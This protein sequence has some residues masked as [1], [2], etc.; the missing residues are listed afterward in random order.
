MSR[1]ALLA[2]LAFGFLAGLIVFAPLE[3][4]LR[5]S[6][7]EARGLGWS[8]AEGTILDGKLNGI[9]LDGSSQG[10]AELKLMPLA[11]LSGQLQYAV[12][13][14]GDHGE[15]AGNVSIGTGAR[16]TLRQFDLELD[17]LRLD[18]AALWIRQSGGRVHLKGE[19]VRFGAAGCVEATGTATSDVLERNIEILGAGWSPMRGELR[20]ES[21]DLV[22]P[23]ESA[24]ASGTRFL[25]QL[26]IAPGRPGRFDARVS[27]L[28]PRE[29]DYALPIAGFT[30]DGADYV[31]SFST[32]DQSGPTR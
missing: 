12:V 7:A 16:A 11:L 20:C 22:I 1:I 13:W 10:N 4:A 3:T 32:S 24:N 25:A 2:L 18:Q 23:L 30:R 26:R 28:L 14:I 9:T 27:G 17:L 31:Y 5:I 21:G 8:K 6:G 19:V 15:G 29:L